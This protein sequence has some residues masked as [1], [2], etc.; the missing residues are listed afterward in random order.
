MI[1][2][3]A[4]SP[5]PAL[6]H[7]VET[8]FNSPPS[9][10]DLRYERRAHFRL[11]SPAPACHS[12]SQSIVSFPEKRGK[13]P[14]NKPQFHKVRFSRLCA[15]C[16]HSVKHES[17]TFCIAREINHHPLLASCYEGRLCQSLLGRANSVFWREGEKSEQ[18]CGWG[19]K[20]QVFIYAALKMTHAPD[21]KQV[22]K[23][24]GFGP[25]CLVTNQG[26]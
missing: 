19:K 2:A 6:H 10:R 18:K 24:R 16:M 8:F 7:H 15:M 20:G 26:T 13:N 1:H 14:I 21:S 4:H 12:P 25:R 9:F 11:V 3:A 5:V 22:V 17:G 23:E